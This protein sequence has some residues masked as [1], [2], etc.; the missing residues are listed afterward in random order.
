[1]AVVRRQRG[2]I[3]E[4]IQQ[5]DLPVGTS[6]WLHSH[7]KLLLEHLKV[8]AAMQLSML[9]LLRVTEC[10]AAL[11]TLFQDLNQLRSLCTF[12]LHC[13]TDNKKH[14][15][16]HEATNVPTSLTKSSIH[17]KMFTAIWPL[18]RPQYLEQVCHGWQT[19][20]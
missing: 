19:L 15:V 9:L 7:M 13:N 16:Y 14:E 5:S 8:F 12:Y 3:Y 4:L 20:M 1:M 6:M 17:E 11:A 10:C 18:C 2:Q